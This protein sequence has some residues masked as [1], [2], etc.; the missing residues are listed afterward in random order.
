MVQRHTVTT[1]EADL[2]VEQLE[3][4]EGLDVVGGRVWR[5]GWWWSSTMRGHVPF[6]SNYERNCLMMLDADPQVSRI[7]HTPIAVIRGPTRVVPPYVVIKDDR[8]NVV[9]GGARGSRGSSEHE[10]LLREWCQ[11][12]GWNLLTLDALAPVAERSLRWLAG[13]RR[14]RISDPA[15]QEVLL[16]RFAKPR[17][18]W[19]G[20]TA[21]GPPS[22]VLPV[23]Y[24][25]LWMGE[26]CMDLEG[27][28]DKGTLIWRRS[29]D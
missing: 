25:L 9:C 13:Y 3:P 6:A 28:L 10:A 20:A 21:S 22:R 5:I 27:G 29:H 1:L 19:D 18:L 4:L 17:P 2:Q 11:V 8:V 23:V 12:A 14:R 24:H 15:I 16:R 7:V 26:L